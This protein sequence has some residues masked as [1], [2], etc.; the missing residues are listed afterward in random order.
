MSL[1]A[2]LK[3]VQDYSSHFKCKILFQVMTEASS[4]TLTT[5]FHCITHGSRNP[6]C[7][8]WRHSC[9]AACR[10][11]WSSSGC[12]S[13][14]CWCPSPRSHGRNSWSG[15]RWGSLSLTKWKILPRQKNNTH[16]VFCHDRLE[17]EVYE[18]RWLHKLWWGV[19]KTRAG[20]CVKAGNASHQI[21]GRETA[22]SALRG[23]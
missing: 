8:K 1:K 22:L 11:R 16:V 5:C 20:P 19:I 15:D 14:P 12:W 13:P 18:W 2:V 23:V 17:Y 6:F 21:R 10:C 7:A 3:T 9:W 4:C